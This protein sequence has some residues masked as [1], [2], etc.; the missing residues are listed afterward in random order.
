MIAF[1]VYE[2]SPS[3]FTVCAEEMEGRPESVRAEL[4]REPVR[5]I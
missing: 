1:C 3:D 5:K 2:F 4:P